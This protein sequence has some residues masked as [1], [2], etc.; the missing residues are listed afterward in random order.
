MENNKEPLKLFIFW[1]KDFIEGKQYADL[2]FEEFS[3]HEY[4]FSGE[5]LG[6]PICFFNE[7]EYTVR[8]L[9]K[10]TQKSAIVFLID[11]KMALDS[12]WR[13]FAEDLIDFTE[14]EKEVIIYPVAVNSFA[15]AKNLS[16]KISKRNFI[17]LQNAR[18]EG[19]TRDEEFAA[20]VEYLKFELVHELSRLLYGRVRISETENRG[21][22]PSVKIFLSH[23]RVDG[24]E[25]AKKMNDAIA[26]TALDRFLDVYSIPKGE[27]FED[28]IR[29][30]LDASALLILYTDSYSS[31]EWCQYEVLYAKSKGR[32]IILVD[33]LER[34]ESR[35]FPYL[36]NVKT[37]HIGDKIDSKEIIKKI[38]YEML[39][40][41]LKVKY[42]QLFLEYL[43]D[44][45]GVNPNETK[46]FSY[47]PEL[48]TLVV[49]NNDASIKN[50]IYPEPPLNHNE[51]NILRRLSPAINFITPTY[52]R[53]GNFQ[54]SRAVF[55]G[56]NIGVS[57][58]EISSEST[59]STT[60]KHLS[61]MYIELCR[62][63]LAM[64]VN[65][66]YG[67]DIKFES[68]YNFVEILQSLVQNYTLEKNRESRI[69][70]CYLDLFTVDE[71]TRATL[72]PIFSFEEIRT[73]NAEEETLRCKNGLTKMRD[74]I[75]D[76]SDLRIAMGGKTEKFLGV[77]PGIIE[78]VMIA[79]E[80]RK[81]VYIIGAYGGAA[82]WMIDCL[83]GKIPEG[84][85]PSVVDYFTKLGYE[86][87]NNGL[88]VEENVELAHTDNWARSIALIISGIVKIFSK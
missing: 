59:K 42:N 3:R 65:L 35:R 22:A 10:N 87:L 39:L 34:G 55:S 88:S 83:E 63:L 25:Y 2:L 18:S 60:N 64:D 7:P 80:K 84:L 56:L 14:Q 29:T 4:D 41:T 48:Y 71:D 73:N 30:D 13:K 69:K 54:N 20:K 15:T 26:H 12:S 31:R 16:A 32:P 75:N 77:I 67:G 43:Q 78:E 52:I 66:I 61:L 38:L 9:I 21:I 23:A 62:Y 5:S 81:P 50:V 70:I 82:K 49:G 46:I 44:L 58:S 57:I 33:L 37:I 68:R 86:G 24:E 40:E 8:S 74:Y 47:P 85:N 27:K 76:I 19:M 72:L 11:S 51:I 1:H 17:H 28:A 36:A 45:H 79:T 53:S 6:I